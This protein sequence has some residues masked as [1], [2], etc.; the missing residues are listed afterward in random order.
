MAKSPY[1]AHMDRRER[2]VNQKNPDTT[3]FEAT[4][5]DLSREIGSIL[6]AT[7]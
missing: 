1:N 3:V 5:L 2:K 7:L 6:P 4:I